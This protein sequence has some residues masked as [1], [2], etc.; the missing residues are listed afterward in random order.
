MKLREEDLKIFSLEN[1][2]NLFLKTDLLAKLRIVLSDI[3]IITTK[4]IFFY[5][6]VHTSA[7]K[8]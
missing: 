3:N 7:Q 2:S 6:D 1:S 8:F 5:G 4:S